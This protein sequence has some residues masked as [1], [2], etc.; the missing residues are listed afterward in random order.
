MHRFPLITNSKS[1]LIFMPR[2]T[3]NGNGNG[4]PPEFLPEKIN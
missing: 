4:K 3:R 1:E 2:E